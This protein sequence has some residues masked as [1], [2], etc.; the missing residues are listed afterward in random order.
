MSVAYNGRE[1]LDKVRQ[2]RPDLIILDVMMSGLNGYDAC[3]EL[4]SDETTKS[5]PVILLASVARN[6]RKTT[7]T[8][9]QGLETEAD[10]Y[11]PKPCKQEDLLRAIANLL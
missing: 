2:K 4:K 11:I 7:Y 8:Q 6:L 9:R 1:C 3:A 10:D 5:I